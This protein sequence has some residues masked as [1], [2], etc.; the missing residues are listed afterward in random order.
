[1]RWNHGFTLIELMIVV[2]IIGIL[3]A[4]AIPN[5]LAMQL[6][7]KRSELPTNLAAI[8]VVERAYYA[9]WDEYTGAGETPDVFPTRTKYPWTGTHKPEWDLLGWAPDGDIYGV[10]EARTR[11]SGFEVSARSDLDGDGT[12]CF[13]YTNELESA[14]LLYANYIY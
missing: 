2:A 5:F 12:Q 8:R 6:R 14:K 3:A 9:E 7:S 4:I 13:Y 1:M 11:P 10:Y